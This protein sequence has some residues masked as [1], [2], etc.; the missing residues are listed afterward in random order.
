MMHSHS[1]GEGVRLESRKI[2]PSSVTTTLFQRAAVAEAEI[3]AVQQ[4]NCK[5]DSRNCMFQK[6]DLLVYGYLCI[7]L[8]QPSFREPL[9][10][11]QKSRRQLWR[12]NEAVRIS[13]LLRGGG[14]DF[15]QSHQPELHVL[16]TKAALIGASEPITSFPDLNERVFTLWFGRELSRRRE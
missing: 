3:S 11:T 4:S 13:A 14:G 5:V 6:L 8:E 12:G 15:L 2:F 9:L 1:E 7:V 16:E 10:L